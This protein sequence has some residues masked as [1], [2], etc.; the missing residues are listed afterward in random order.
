MTMKLFYFA[1]LAALLL[2]LAGCGE[3][4]AGNKSEAAAPHVS[5]KEL[6]PE[7]KFAGTKQKAETGDAEAQLA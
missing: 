4:A 6:T 5:A 2:T 1:V 3:K 7:E